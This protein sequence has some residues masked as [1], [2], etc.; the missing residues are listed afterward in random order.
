MPYDV[1]YGQR[2]LD[3]LF[4][5]QMPQVLD[6]VEKAIARLADDPVQHSRRG[7]TLRQLPNGRTFRPQEFRFPLRCTAWATR[8]LPGPLLLRGRRTR[9]ARDRPRSE[10]LLASLA[11]L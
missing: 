2:A 10:T 5:L 7:R 8:A 9:V 1:V 11:H 3:A 6:C 4:D